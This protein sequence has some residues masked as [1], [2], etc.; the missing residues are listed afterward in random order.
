MTETETQENQE[1]DFEEI[2]ED[3]D[4]A[5]KRLREL[6]DDYSNWERYLCDGDCSEAE[7]EQANRQRILTLRKIVFNLSV[8]SGLHRQLVSSIFKTVK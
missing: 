8:D 3:I 7:Y 5:I 1:I 2:I 4:C 6:V